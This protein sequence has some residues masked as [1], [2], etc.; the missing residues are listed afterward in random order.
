[1]KIKRIRIQNFQSIKD[2][3]FNFDES[4]V[5]YFNG[6]N[7]IGKSSVLKAIRALFFNVN[8][9]SYKDYIRDDEDSFSIALEDFD[10][11]W[12]V[13]TR[14]A[15]DFYKWKINGETGQLNRTSG[16]VPEELTK[17][18]NLYRDENTK[19]CANIR[20]P[21]AV[22]LGVDTSEGDNNLFLQKALNSS[23]FTKAYKQAD[24]DKRSKMKELK[25]IETYIDRTENDIQNVNI[26]E[27][28]LEL[29][30]IQR[31]EDVLKKEK[32]M[33]LMVHDALILSEN[34]EHYRSEIN[35]MSQVN[36]SDINNIKLNIDEY[37]LLKDLSSSHKRIVT[38]NEKLNNINIKGVNKSLVEANQLVNEI[39]LLNQFKTSKQR[40][41]ELLLELNNINLEQ[42]AKNL[43]E[44]ESL[45]QEISLLNQNK[46]LLNNVINYS[47]I[48]ES[49]NIDMI[50]VMNEIQEI[51]DE[52]GVC[53]LCGTS[54]D[55]NNIH[56]HNDL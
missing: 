30:K 35:R 43:I 4:G 20:P 13:L 44:L 50:N 8:N 2:I 48:L 29:Q 14:G 31:Y 33:Y 5:Y 34:I 10:G 19:E 12:V 37:N 32:E 45:I 26:D 25:M 27:V 40:E 24:S 54:F 3:T 16:K 9:L 38:Y 17:Y 56:T 41:Q 51:K 22:L 6:D 53:P 11:N 52:L 42:D 49:S 39:N 15:S 7:N 46:T 28:E 18:F 47:D 36:L 1:M 55:S 21:R 23:G